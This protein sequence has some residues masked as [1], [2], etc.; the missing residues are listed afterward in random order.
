MDT[1]ARHRALPLPTA[2]LLSRPEAAAYVRVSPTT[3][4]KM[5]AEGLMPKP[6]KFYGCVRWDLKKLD[7]AIDCLPGDGVSTE[8][9]NPWG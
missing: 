3:F 7:H 8:D 2:R 1:P 4:D 9:A 6:K 5:I